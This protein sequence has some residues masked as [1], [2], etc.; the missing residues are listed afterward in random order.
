MMKDH[1][2]AAILMAE[3][4]CCVEAGLVQP[5]A[6]LPA[7]FRFVRESRGVE[8]VWYDCT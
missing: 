7:C 6:C 3:R 4:G 8:C 1:F 2:S 5:P